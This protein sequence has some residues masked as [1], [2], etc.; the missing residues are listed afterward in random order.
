MVFACVW[1]DRVHEEHHERPGSLRRGFPVLPK[2]S[3]QKSRAGG[4]APEPDREEDPEPQEGACPDV[5]MRV[6][7]QEWW[8]ETESEKTSWEITF[9][10][11]FTKA[12][13][14]STELL[15]VRGRR[16]LLLKGTLYLGYHSC[17]RRTEEVFTHWKRCCN[18]SVWFVLFF[19]SGGDCPDVGQWHLQQQAG[20]VQDVE[21][22]LHPD[23][24]HQQ[25]RGLHLLRRAQK[26][27][28][29]QDLTTFPDCS[30]PSLSNQVQWTLIRHKLPWARTPRTCDET[31]K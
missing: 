12:S 1:A 10:C 11:R 14:V 30:L 18:P 4:G 17:G 7:E 8:F 25:S 19:F 24:H 26:V 31:S 5:C 23:H 6:R 27:I 29:G 22:V 20:D 9:W 16:G 28:D 15:P 3:A 13:S 2:S 21:G